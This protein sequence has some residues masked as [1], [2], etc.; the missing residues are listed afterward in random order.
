MGFVQAD[1]IRSPAR[2][3]DLIL[4]HRVRGYR[5]GDLE[6]TYPTLDIEEDYLYAYGFVSRATWR[7]LHPRQAVKLTALE[8]RILETVRRQ[9]ETHPAQLEKYFGSKRVINAWGGNSKE[10]TRALDNLHYRGFLRIARRDNGIRVYTAARP[11]PEPISP[12]ERLRKRILATVNILAPVPA[13]T[14]QTLTAPL[15]RRYF[16]GS[17]SARTVLSGLLRTGE[18]KKATVGGSDYFLPP[19]E[20]AAG[21]TPRRVLFLAPFDPLIWDR[22]R[23]EHFWGWPYRFEAYTP[24]AKRL[25]GYYAM[26]MLWGDD[27]IGWANANVTGK[28]LNVELGFVSKRPGDKEFSP[29]L[30]AE[31][32]AL[33]KFLNLRTKEPGSF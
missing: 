21:E 14:L 32:S 18:L 17:G 12:A 2:A 28:R 19:V 31:I 24:P 27:I 5:I 13:K 4:R 20:M 6:R 1:P 16:P 29:A 23:F 10:T 33:K 15:L 11:R 25:R 9:G 30:D 8:T 3:Q 22:R 7:I 26:P